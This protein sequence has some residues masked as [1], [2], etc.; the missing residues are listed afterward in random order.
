MLAACGTEKITPPR[1]P[2]DVTVEARTVDGASLPTIIEEHPGANIQLIAFRV[3]LWPE[4][5]WYA[6][7]SRRPE[8]EAVGDT[9]A[10][11]DNG[12][13]Q[14]DGA[15]ILLHSNFTNTDWPGTIHGDTIV[16]DV[17]LP[18]ASA[19]HAILFAP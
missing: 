12:W 14:S 7:G 19:K 3:E 4:G 10:F 1:A 15:A 16:A 11:N 8:G 2:L 13:Y 18:I 9:S 5:Q 17:S 6:R